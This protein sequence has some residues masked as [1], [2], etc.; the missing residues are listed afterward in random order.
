VLAFFAGNDIFDAEAFD[1]FQRSGGA[2][3]RTPLGWRIKDVVSR[4]DSWFVVSVLRAGSRSF[5]AHQGAVAAAEPDHAPA[6][7]VDASEDPSPGFDRGWFELPVAGR[8]MRWAFMPPYLNTLNFWPS[9]STWT[10]LASLSTSIG[11][12]RTASRRTS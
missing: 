1:A 2:I 6:R 7:P 9:A 4:V 5:N 3:K 11:C 10:L 12:W 8:Q